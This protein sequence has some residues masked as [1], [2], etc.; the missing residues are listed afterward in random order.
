[1][2][3]FPRLKTGAVAQYP[4]TR[5]Q[6]FETGICRFLD[7]SE[8]R[9]RSRGAT[10]RWAIRLGLLDEGEMREI[11]EFFRTT[12]G[13]AGSFSFEDPWDGMVHPDCSLES[14]ELMIEGAGEGR[15]NTELVIKE[16]RG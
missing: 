2:A 6:G 4:A 1:M 8:Q 15:H 14:D 11:E 9:Y 5:E 12:Q 13:A 16:N 10:R 7:G 3:D